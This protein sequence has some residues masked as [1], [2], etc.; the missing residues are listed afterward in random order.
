MNA[1]ASAAWPLTTKEIP[2]LRGVVAQWRA[3]GGQI[4]FVPT[5]GALHA[6]HLALVREAKRRCDHVVVSIFV[7][8]AQF[9]PNEDFSRYPRTV[10][11]DLQL[12][13][14]HAD[15]VWLPEVEDIYPSGSGAKVTI[16][17]A[18]NILCGAHRPGHFDG[19]ATVV[20]ILL[21][22]VIPDVS[23]FGEK[24]YQQLHII[25]RMVADLGLPG[26]IQGVPTIREPDGLAL[27][28]RNRYLSAE[29]RAKASL[30]HEVLQSVA[31]RSI[32]STHLQTALSE[33]RHTLT[34]AGFV[35]D[36]LE[37]RDD[38]TLVQINAPYLHGR[39]FVAARLGNTRLID[40]L[41]LRDV[42]V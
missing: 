30:L 34:E 39:L 37:A 1:H 10:E 31:R 6:G 21:N 13:A 42:H 36:Y 16:G 25:R 41:A 38:R 2:N 23:F 27:S 32:D 35:I 20:T 18:A 24:D 9:G 4:G 22:A 26:E 40:N 33:G 15:L 5:M 17:A 29:E 19:V 14:G 7:N 8:P 28:S 11:A 12:L 3:Y